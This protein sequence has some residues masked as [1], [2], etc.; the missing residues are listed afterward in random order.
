MEEEEA[1]TTKPQP[2]ATVK[3][4]SVLSYLCLQAKAHR[5]KMRLTN[6]DRKFCEECGCVMGRSYRYCQCNESLRLFGYSPHGPCFKC[7]SNE[8]AINADESP[9]DDADQ[10]AANQRRHYEAYRKSKRIRCHKR[11]ASCQ[12][13]RQ[14]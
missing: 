6:C 10:S 1:N 4:I 13:L 9:D 3:N 14:L 5:G 11:C 2:D 8:A 12:S 7:K